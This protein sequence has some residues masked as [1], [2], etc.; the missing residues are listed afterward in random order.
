MFSERVQRRL[1]DEVVIWMT[2]VNASGKPQTS[3]VWYWW[4]GSSFLVYSLD[5]SARVT[6]VAGNPN[7]ALNLDVRRQVPPSN[8][9][10]LGRTRG[11]RREVSNCNPDH[12][13]QSARMVIDESGSPR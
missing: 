3:V 5:P 12:S 11:L 6:N 4:D 2:T 13:H 10:G 7:V 1:D 8:G 9:S